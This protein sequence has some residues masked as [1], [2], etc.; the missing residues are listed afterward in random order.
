MPK[1]IKS[2]D[3]DDDDGD[4]EVCT[5]IYFNP[6]DITNAELRKLPSFTATTNTIFCFQTAFNRRLCDQCGLSMYTCPSFCLTVSRIKSADFIETC[7]YDWAYQTE[8]LLTFGGDPVPDT[9]SE[10]LFHFP[11][12]CR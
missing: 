12:Y 7:F 3:D 6:G 2:V 11:N 1:Q 8:D 10:S 4:D 5:N 9:H